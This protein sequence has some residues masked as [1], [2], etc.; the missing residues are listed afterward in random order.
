MRKRLQDRVWRRAQDTC[1][2]CRM[3]S[4]FYRTPFHI[5]HIV[6]RQHGGATTSDNLA[7]ACLHCDLHK[8]TNLARIDPHTGLL[9]RLYHP[10]HDRWDDHFEWKGP[11]LEGLS[12]VGRTT[13]ALLAINDPAY[14]TVRT[15][16]IEEHVFPKR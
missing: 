6:A 14:V 16:L 9:T 5:D 11:R 10:R 1:E 8:G 2:Y 7:L 3:P 15:A 4:R 13:I 12:D